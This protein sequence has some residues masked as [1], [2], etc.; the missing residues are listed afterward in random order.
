MCQNLTSQHQQTIVQPKEAITS[1]PN[2]SSPSSDAVVVPLSCSRKR[3]ACQTQLSA[4]EESSVKMMKDSST[5]TNAATSNLCRMIQQEQVSRSTH[6]CAALKKCSGSIVPVNGLWRERVAT[7]FY[8]V[9]DYL[10]ESRDVAYVAMNLL[11]RYL[12]VLY[13]ENQTPP[14]LQPFEFEVMAFTS[15]F[16]AVRVCGDNK[17]LEIPELLQLS[18]SGAKPRHILEAGHHMLEKLSWTHRTPT[19]HAFLKEYLRLLVSAGKQQ[20][21]ISRHQAASLLDFA[22]YLVEVSVCDSYFNAL[23]ASEVALG[24]L[25]VAM[26]C[27]ATFA[28]HQGFLASFFRTMQEH[29]SIQIESEHMKDIISRLLDV[30]NQSHEASV[31]SSTSNNC[32]DDSTNEHNQL[33]ASINACVP[34]MVSPHVIIDDDD[35]VEE[36]SSTTSEMPLLAMALCQGAMAV[37]ELRSI[38]PSTS[39]ELLRRSG[40]MVPLAE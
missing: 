26:T 38:S 6:D 7:W 5:T 19:P 3:K 16:L 17:E 35:D 33:G 2:L 29:T 8:N 30:Y 18:S 1:S 14:D 27:D 37:D 10:E 28:P 40:D 20:S 32:K 4:L 25:V 9:L 21:I 23:A 11:D 34:A 13:Q 24:S 22:S 36:N 39:L 15:L 12:A 31:S